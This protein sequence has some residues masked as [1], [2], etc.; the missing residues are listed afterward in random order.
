F[1][2]DT[3]LDES[4]PAG[5]RGRLTARVRQQAERIRRQYG[6]QPHLRANLL[7]ALGRMCARVDAVDQADELLHE[8]RDIRLAAFGPE[9]LEIA[10][11]LSSLGFLH[12]RR[13]EFAAAAEALERALDLHRRL[14]ADV[15]TD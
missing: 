13:G 6:D 4:E 9:S 3:F 2:S 15:H 12:Y 11:S 14:P 10:L 7:D 1:L 5:G 8:A